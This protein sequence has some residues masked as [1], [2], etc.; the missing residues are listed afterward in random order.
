MTVALFGLRNSWNFY[1]FELISV[2][3]LQGK[4]SSF[5]HDF[6][7][8]QSLA[9]HSGLDYAVMTGGDVAP[10]GHDGVSAMHKVFDWAEHTRKG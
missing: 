5:I 4:I 8:F 9:H 6:N 7:L 1:H 2:V 10:L 3:L